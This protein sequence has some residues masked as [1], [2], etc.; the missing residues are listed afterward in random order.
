MSRPKYM[1]EMIKILYDNPQ[2]RI[3]GRE[4]TSSF[5]EQNT[6]IRQGCPPSPYLFVIF[7]TVPFNDVHDELEGKLEEA[8]FDFIDFIE[9]LYADDTLL[10]GDNAKILN[11]LLAAIAKTL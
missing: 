8:T 4:G 3:K 7:M 1:L 10:I 2:F 5:R 9:I 6:S 11:L